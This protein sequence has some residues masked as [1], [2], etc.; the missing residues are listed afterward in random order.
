MKSGEFVR[1]IRAV[2]FLLPLPNPSTNHTQQLESSSII[3][4]QFRSHSL[5]SF[6]HSATGKY[7]TIALLYL[8]RMSLSLRFLGTSAARPTVERN[9][10]SIAL[11]REG[12]AFLFDC[13]E[14]TQRQMMR[15]GIT[16]N[17]DDI[18]FTH[19]H[20]DH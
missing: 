1:L 5:R 9:V 8:T 18:F 11:L 4:L 10:S 20:T 7:A 16:F 2:T 6:S 19:F 17:L 15:Y 14:G 12:E 13:G 3:R